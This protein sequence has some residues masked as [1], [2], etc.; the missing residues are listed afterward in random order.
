METKKSIFMFVVMF[1][2]TSLNSS[3]NF[4]F[5]G[6]AWCADGSLLDM[7]CFRLSPFTYPTLHQQKTPL[8]PHLWGATRQGSCFGEKKYSHNTKGCQKYSTPTAHMSKT[9][10]NG[11]RFSFCVI[12]SDLALLNR[13]LQREKKQQKS[14]GVPHEVWL[15]WFYAGCW[16]VAF[17]LDSE[18]VWLRSAGIWWRNARIKF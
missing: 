11:F 5:L 15:V 16:Y 1:V 2:E 14:P 9:S 3:A 7:P 6:H 8:C 17:T 18:N 13:V 4:G 10:S 12:I